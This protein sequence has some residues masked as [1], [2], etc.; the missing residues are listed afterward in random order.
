[1]VLENITEKKRSILEKRGIESD[2]DLAYLSPYKYY[3]FSTL[4]ELSPENVGKYLCIAG[5]VTSVRKKSGAGRSS[6]TA[7]L[8]TDN[9]QLTVTYLGQAFMEALLEKLKGEV[10]FVCGK[11]EYSQDFKMYSMLNPIKTTPNHNILSWY[12]VYPKYK[13]IGEEFLQEQTE[14]ALKG[15]E[16]PET[17]PQSILTATGLPRRKESIDILKHP[18][19][20][21][22][23]RKAIQR[24]VFEDA[25]Y[26]A[27]S[28]ERSSRGISPGSPY[29]VKRRVA[30][31]KVLSTLPYSLTED[32]G[33]CVEEVLKK[34]EAGRHV[35]ALVQG[36][37]GCGK[38][39]VA[40]L[41]MIAMADS[42]WQSALM[43]PTVVLAEQHY[44]ELSEYAAICGFNVAFLGGKKTKKEEHIMQEG[45]ADGS[46][47]LVV[48]THALLSDKVVFN[49]LG[50]CIVDEEHRFGVKQREKLVEKA[51]LGV[52]DI[53]FSAT[54][55]PRSMTKAIY[56]N[57]DVY[58]IKSM[59]SGRKAIQ[60]AVTGSDGA[61]LRFVKKQLEEGSQA[62]VVC[63]LI[64]G[65]DLR[66]RTVTEVA[67]L[68][69]K[70]LGTKV[71]IVTGKTSKKELEETLAA[72]KNNELK[73]LCATT[74]IEVGVNVPN[75][76]VIVIEDAWMFGLAQLHQLRGR[77][78]RGSKQGYCILKS[79]KDV[80]RLNVLCST[81]DGFEIAE[82]D[83]K[84]RGA[85]N[86]LGQEQS[87]K[88]RFLD[89]AM[90]Y[91]VMFAK[92][93][94]YA[95]IM[96][97]DGTDELLIKEMEKR[98]DKIFVKPEKIK[99]FA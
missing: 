62:Y 15:T 76:T 30:V 14:I 5:S 50:L 34:L 31:N 49:N 82:E 38:S 57:C 51:R 8:D 28:L 83:A 37:V 99:I 46:I 11:L 80:E 52:H 36:D 91:P 68:Y 18:E 45:I 59:P 95:K 17:I 97:D 77:V 21:R 16:L 53:H 13:G 65:E 27:C 75:A 1:M 35:S 2:I 39:I 94:E 66:L 26:F 89:V 12:P 7:K 40:F 78:G 69:E 84:L 92:A 73:V 55:I 56:G 43:A 63:P 64:D 29:N 10:I 85:G 6:V 70:E 3:D 54:P 24:Q 98:S 42:G 90:N 60:T 33:K 25:L 74:V 61:T 67:K 72:F 44:K 23:L 71:G 93:K 32:Q 19:E 41:L 88:N 22:E 86:I 96:V 4:E 58:E 20:K 48:G 47:Q 81:T 9:G 79:D 87:G